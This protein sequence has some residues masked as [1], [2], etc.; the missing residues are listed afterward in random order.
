MTIKNL[1]PDKHPLIKDLHKTSYTF[2]GQI[3]YASCPAYDIYSYPKYDVSNKIVGLLHY[4]FR[5]CELEVLYLTLENL[6]SMMNLQD[7]INLCK[8][9]CIPDCDTKQIIFDILLKTGKN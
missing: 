2:N 4:N 8:C 6:V 1:Y 9:L 7:F 5:K 3:M